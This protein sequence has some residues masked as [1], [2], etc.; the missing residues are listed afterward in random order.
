MNDMNERFREWGVI[1]NVE[2][3]V[4]L[5]KAQELRGSIYN[6]SHLYPAIF[7]TIGLPRGRVL[8]VGSY[9]ERFAR[10]LYRLG[11]PLEVIPQYVVSLDIRELNT[12]AINLVR[13]TGK[14]LPF[15]DG[16]F[17]SV[18]SLG[19]LPMFCTPNVPE[20]AVLKEMLRVA[21]DKVIICPVSS[22]LERRVQKL[23]NIPWMYNEEGLCI[24]KAQI[25]QLQD[26]S[27]QALVLTKTPKIYLGHDTSRTV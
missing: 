19:S 26:S 15:R 12:K 27:F 9:C 14:H 22:D 16:S 7:K 8:D 23:S 17:H 1:E 5:E 18:I 21:S 25:I 4:R 13:G 11:V 2:E 24:A 20:D 10:F 6:W 3:S